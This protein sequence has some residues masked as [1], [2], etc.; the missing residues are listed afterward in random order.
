MFVRFRRS[1]IPGGRVPTAEHDQDHQ[2]VHREHGGHL[3]QHHLAALRG[4][5]VVPQGKHPPQPQPAGML[6]NTTK[7]H[8]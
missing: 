7:I 5:P 8:C 3:L 2:V 1:Q 6:Q 4:G